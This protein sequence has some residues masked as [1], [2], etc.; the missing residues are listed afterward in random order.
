MKRINIFEFEDIKG[1]PNELRNGMTDYLRFVLTFLNIYEPV[2]PI[3]NRV[4]NESKLDCIV[5]TCSGGGGAIET[6]YGLLAK[7]NPSLKIVLTDLYPNA[8]SFELIKLRSAG[9]I[10]FWHQPV[11][12]ANVPSELNGVRTMFSAFHHFSP[13]KAKEV[14]Q[15]AI[16]QKKPVAVFDGGEKS[17]LMVIMLIFFH[18]LFF[19]FFTPFIR[20]FKVYRI[21]F[22][23]ILPLIPLCTIW[24]GM[25][26][27][28][29][30]YNPEQM[31]AMANDVDKG[32]Y[33][34]DSGTVRG[35]NGIK[36]N[37]L[38]GWPAQ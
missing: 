16:V 18:P 21:V 20:P 32:S 30:L 26:S 15:D 19:F 27:I 31:Q 33:N 37:Y 38:V 35:R 25:A 8:T 36:V 28:L 3:I 13:G 9:R 7:N 4:L 11:D 12:A 24:D 17:L 10:S 34:W 5:D 23:Y 6:I 29:R 1:F 14:L 2:V 22:T